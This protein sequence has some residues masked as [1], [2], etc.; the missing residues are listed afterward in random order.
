LSQPPKQGLSSVKRAPVLLFLLIIPFLSLNAEES[1]EESREVSVLLSELRA[2][3]G[4][5]SREL[6]SLLTLV[7]D[8]EGA[9]R[10]WEEAG[11]FLRASRCLISLGEYERAL[12]L[13][14]ASDTEEALTLAALAQ[15]LLL[16][17]TSALERSGNQG[18]IYL[19]ALRGEDTYFQRLVEADRTSA[20]ALLLLDKRISLR[21]SPFWLLEACKV[22]ETYTGAAN[23]EATSDDSS[24]SLTA[25]YKVLLQTGLFSSE[26]NAEKQRQA[27]AKL[28]FSAEVQKKGNNWAVYVPAAESEVNRTIM[29]LN[30]KGYLSDPVYECQQQGRGDGK[31]VRQG[32]AGGQ[33]QGS[34]VSA[35]RSAAVPLPAGEVR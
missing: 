20:N 2:G 17:D 1:A 26:D 11:D 25:A 7:G 4:A 3:E 30:D 19:A 35:A 32:W 16:D 15:S 33:A 23:A 22:P 9:A 24:P 21:L 14:T 18:L 28:G 31:R 5:N 13:L 27:L 34:A 12:A 10:V 6:A 29:A 8:I